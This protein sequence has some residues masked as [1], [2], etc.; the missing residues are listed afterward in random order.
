MEKFLRLEKWEPL[1][2]GVILY[3]YAILLGAAYLLAYWRPFGFDIFPYVT[4][5]LLLTLPL[6]RLSVLLAPLVLSG[7]IVFLNWGSD[8]VR[9]PFFVLVFAAHA[10]LVLSNLYDGF[11]RFRSSGS[12]YENE[13]SILVLVLVLSVS[14]AFTAIQAVLEKRSARFLLTSIAMLQLAAALAAGYADGK[15]IYLGAGNTFFLENAAACE[16]HP[17]RNWVYLGRFDDE[18]IFMNTIEKRL[19]IL[20]N[21]QITLIPRSLADKRIAVS[22]AL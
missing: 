19:C 15:G 12:V 21:P 14:A 7:L 17:V 22:H 18:T 16:P 4:P 9:R 3:G 1:G 13:K 20:Q 6:N 8:S 11:E 5:Q 10:W 2:A